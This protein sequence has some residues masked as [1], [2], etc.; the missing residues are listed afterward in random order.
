[1]AFMSRLG[2]ALRQVARWSDSLQLRGAGAAA[3]SMPAVYVVSR[4]MASS[5][6]FVGG[7]AWG[8]DENTLREAFSSYG[9]VIDVKIITDRDTGRS[10]GFGFI[11]FTNDGDAE[12]ALQAMDGRNVA[13]RTIRVDYAVQKPGGFGRGLGGGLGSGLG[14]FGGENVKR[15]EFGFV[16]KDNIDSSLHATDP[17][18]DAND[19]G[20][21][22]S[23][24]G[25]KSNF[26]SNSSE[27]SSF[28]SW[29]NL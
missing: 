4:G 1:M 23:N 17:I 8:A 26:D 12:S 6:L 3:V 5:K 22:G 15:D 24:S 13:G 27:T 10:R 9:E 21:F 7:L 16:I 28:G 18:A 29:K 19:T 14:G 2:C 20:S 25:E 11:S